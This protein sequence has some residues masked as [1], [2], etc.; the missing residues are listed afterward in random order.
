MRNNGILSGSRS[1]ETIRYYVG[2]PSVLS[3]QFTVSCDAETFRPDF[4]DLCGCIPENDDVLYES[5]FG[6]VCS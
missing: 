6:A 3:I 4:S 2:N 1:H 5:E